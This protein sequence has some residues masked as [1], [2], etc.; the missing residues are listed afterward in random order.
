MRSEAPKRNRIMGAD[1]DFIRQCHD[2]ISSKKK[3]AVYVPKL[4]VRLRNAKGKLP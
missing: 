4:V 3:K 1:E 2:S